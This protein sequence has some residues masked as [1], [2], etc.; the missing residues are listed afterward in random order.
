ML[1]S[2]NLKCIFFKI[3]LIKNFQMEAFY[4]F[5]FLIEGGDLENAVSQRWE[6]LVI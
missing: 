4:N 1:E 5:F 6:V 2:G 3:S